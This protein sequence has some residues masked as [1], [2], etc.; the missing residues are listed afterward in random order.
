[1]RERQPACRSSV[2]G[3]DAW[4]FDLPE[5]LDQLSNIKVLPNTDEEMK[6]QLKSII[7]ICSLLACVATAGRSE[8]K[9]AQETDLQKLQGEWKMISGLADGYAV[10]EEMLRTSS[11]VCKADETT[12]VVGGQLIMKA[13]F[14]LDSAKKPKTIDYSILEG[15]AKGNKLLGIYELNGDTV[16]FCFAANAAD[17]PTNFSSQLGD[18]R[19]FSVWQRKKESGAAQK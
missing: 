12:V 16:K 10:P 6:E 18:R 5:S 1:M 13:R 9:K 11:R 7:I 15:S 8:D 14:T 17:R 19:T 2:P 3:C 4:Q